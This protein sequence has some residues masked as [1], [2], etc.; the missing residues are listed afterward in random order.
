MAI[1]Q[2]SFSVDLIGRYVCNSWDEAV[3]SG[4]TPFD[5][6]VVGAGMHG[7]YCAEKIYRFAREQAKPIRILVLDA[8]SVLLTQHEQNYPNIS[9]NPG[10][11]KIVTSNSNDPGPQETVWGYPW[12]SNQDF[13]G[14]AY[15][16][17]GRSIYWGGWA[18]RLTPDDLIDWPADVKSH[19]IPNY[20]I[21][22]REIGVT[23][24]AHEPLTAPLKAKFTAAIG[25]TT[26]AVE[27]PPLAVQSSAPTG[28]LFAFDKYSS[29]NLLIEALREDATRD[30]TPA[31]RQ[32]LLVPRANVVR[33][34]N[35]GTNVT[36]IDV[37]VNG[38]QRTIDI[39]RVLK[40][41]VKVVVANGTIEATRLALNSFPAAGM[42]ANLMA[43]T[44]S[45]TTVRI[46]RA[47]LGLGAPTTL[48]TGMLLV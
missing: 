39:T 47:E 6:V 18:P 24:V 44:R 48:E 15:C 42:G 27:E 23:A 43:H 33:L 14:L 21:V 22:E 36:G 32:I 10:P 30:P 1:E 8:G 2:T 45:N 28:L 25:G 20:P 41:N 4:G 34:A 16:I 40:P 7:G 37:M 5:I 12:R 17:G 46:P 9:P 19:L 26:V 35:N 13:P 29:A 11:A 3:N 31:N 38:Q